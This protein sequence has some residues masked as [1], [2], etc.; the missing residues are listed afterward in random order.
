MNFGGMKVLQFCG[1][2]QLQCLTEATVVYFSSNKL[3]I[4]IGQVLLISIFSNCKTKNFREDKFLQSS[5]RFTKILWK[6]II[7]KLIPLTKTLTAKD[8]ALTK[9]ENTTEN[10]NFKITVFKIMANLMNKNF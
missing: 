1:W 5:K 2:A 3:S 10:E 8:P 9:N 6:L 4:F 7:Q